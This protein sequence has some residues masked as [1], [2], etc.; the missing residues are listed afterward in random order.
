[1]A[2]VLAAV[3][4]I[5]L[6][7]WA[8]GLHDLLRMERLARLRQRVADFGPL[9][10][11]VYV[12]GYVLA[13]L[14]FLPALPLT[15]LA[16]LV[17]GPVWGTVWASVGATLG[18]AVAFLVAR[19]VLRGT[20]ERWM[21]ASPRLSRLD[22]AVARHDW[23]ILMFTRLVPIFPFT[24]QNFVYGLTRIRFGR[25]VLVTWLCSL[26]GTAAYAVA[27]AAVTEGSGD[28]RRV[29]AWLAVAAVLIIALS[30]APRLLRRYQTLGAL[31]LGLGSAVAAA[32][33]DRPIGHPPSA[34]HAFHRDLTRAHASRDDIALEPGPSG[35]MRVAR[36]PSRRP[37]RRI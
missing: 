28:P 9:A 20:V 10:P 22:D 34:P 30:F 26:P 11:A 21:A 4:A 1:M 37:P 12:G 2:L 35:E 14:L 16:G 8:L 3:A 13:E 23:R 32:A 27:A 24:L 33:D 29:V 31:L 5:A 36:A 19:H 17:F 6:V 25:Y 15:L 18:A 7:A